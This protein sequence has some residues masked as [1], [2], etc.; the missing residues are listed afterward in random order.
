MEEAI[1]LGRRASG[2]E[3]SPVGRFH[4]DYQ[5]LWETIGTP[6]RWEEHAGIGAIA[7]GMPEL[8]KLEVDEPC[9]LCRVQDVIRTRI[10]MDIGPKRSRGGHGSEEAG[11]LPGEGDLDTHAK[12][13]KV[14]PQLEDLIERL[15]TSWAKVT[16]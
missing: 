6:A 14:H 4:L 5:G 13:L 1:V 11:D 3:S 7:Q 9:L 2:H 10:A 15:S 16:A 8:S 12:S